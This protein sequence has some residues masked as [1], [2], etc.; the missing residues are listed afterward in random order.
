MKSLRVKSK[1][2]ILLIFLFFLLVP[3]VVEAKEYKP[4]VLDLPAESQNEAGTV[5]Y[6]IKK[7]DTLYSIGRKFNCTADLI[8]AING[9]S[10]P[11]LIKPNQEILIPK[12]MEVTHEVTAGETIWSIAAL[13]GVLPQQ[14]IFAND[15]WFPDRLVQGTFLEIPI[16]AQ[17]TIAGNTVNKI[18]S[19][20]KGSFMYTPT[21][22][23]LSSV[24]G[25][26]GK[27]FH[28]GI[29]LANK[30]G[31]AINAAQAGKVTFVGWKGNY[32]WTVVIDHLN[33]YK[34][35][36]GHNSKILVQKGQW[37]E[38]GQKIALMGNTGRSTGPHLH[39]EIY[40]NGKVVDPLKYIYLRDN[41][42]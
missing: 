4:L 21:V 27:E 5:K 28:T 24:F 2:I 41:D 11:H 3:L 42:Y 34:T 29:D 19:R 14:I 25:S 7:G 9:I 23:V 17:V 10:N 30:Q 20:E 8:A 40:E 38:K 31:T 37:V 13:Y 12:I 22:G 36:Y 32:G 16:T 1:G 35:L 15:I 26:R 18:S 33:G 6:V 39:F